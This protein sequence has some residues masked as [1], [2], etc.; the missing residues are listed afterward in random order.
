MSLEQAVAREHIRDTMARYNIAGD[1]RNLQAFVDTFSDDA[2]YESSPFHCVGKPAILEY[3]TRTWNMKP[4]GPTA[5][6]RR[7]N[8]T[9]SQIDLTSATTA[10]ARTYYFVITDLGPDHCGFYVDQFREV[11]GR[12]L[13]SHREVWMDWCNPGSLFVPDLSKKM[14]ADQGVCGPEAAIKAGRRR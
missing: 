1:S 13:I 3:L 9:T 6:F 5:R 11:K 14:L 2:V 8:L 12:W 10:D 4:A 7:H